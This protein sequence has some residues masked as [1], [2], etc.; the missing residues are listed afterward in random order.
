METIGSMSV[1]DFRFAVL[2]V[3][4]LRLTQQHRL[5]AEGGFQVLLEWSTLQYSAAKTNVV[6]TLFLLPLL[7]L[8]FLCSFSLLIITISNSYN[9]PIPKPRNW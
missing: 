9:C 7:L 5:R 8:L 3:R 4:V 1:S 2:L 6:N